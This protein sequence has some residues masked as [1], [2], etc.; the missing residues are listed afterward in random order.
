MPARRKS[1]QRAI[2][3][4]FLWDSRKLSLDD[5]FSS[6]CE[7]LYS[8][9]TEEERGDDPGTPMGSDDF[10]ESLVR[11][12]AAAVSE[13]DGY[14]TVRAEHWRLER[15]PIVDRNI[16]R[17][18]IYEMKYLGTAPAI[19]IDEA[20][21]LARRYSNL[22]SVPFVNGVLDAVRKLILPEP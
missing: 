9:E 6:Y 22:E 8:A 21:E 17:M 18:A 10:M 20:L 13:L 12:T 3:V 5:A 16:L 1:R 19:V 14:I 7:S 4:L 11:G 15:M 2:Q